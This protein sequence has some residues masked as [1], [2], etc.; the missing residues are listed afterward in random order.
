MEVTATVAPTPA[1]KQKSED[2]PSNAIVGASIGF[3][4]K[5]KVSVQPSASS[6]DNV[7]VPAAERLLKVLPD[8]GPICGPTGG[9]KVYLYVPQPPVAFALTLPKLPLAQLIAVT[10]LVDK[11]KTGASSI[12]KEVVSV[13]PV[14]ASVTVMV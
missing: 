8:L 7:Y 14:S 2:G 10:V 9:V 13:Q 4:S 5:V 3:K 6:T 12:S 1:T 11:S